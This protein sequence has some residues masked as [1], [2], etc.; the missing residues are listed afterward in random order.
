MV[1]VSGAISAYFLLKTVSRDAVS[2]IFGGLIM[3]LKFV[4]A[5]ALLAVGAVA[6][7]GTGFVSQNG[8]ALSLVTETGTSANPYAIGTLDAMFSSVFVTL[9][10]AGSFSEFATFMVP[11]GY[12]MVNGAANTYAL[13]ITLPNPIGL[14]TI[15]SISNFNMD[16]VDGSPVLPG[17]TQA[18]LGAGGSVL[19]LGL[20]P[21]MYHL[22]F[23][24]MVNGAGG[25]YSAA[26][27]ATPVPEPET[28]AMLLAGLGA[29][30]FLARRRK[31]G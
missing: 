6:Q 3:K 28:Y 4:A 22:H 18:S 26:I 17:A 12:N 16:I 31:N 21:G 13:S 2:Q 15:G 23:T 19:N 30:G 9:G 20:T 10:T 1:Q 25:Q 27:N 24:G 5:A 8:G 11:A 7:A 29:V 14:I